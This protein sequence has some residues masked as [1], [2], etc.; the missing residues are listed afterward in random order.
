MKLLFIFLL[1][2]TSIF[3]QSNPIEVELQLKNSGDESVNS[4]SIITVVETG[5]VIRANAGSKIQI[6][7]EK[8]GFYTFKV[9]N[10]DKL[11]TFRKEVTY[12]GQVIKLYVKEILKGGIEVVG[13]KEKNKL[14]RY[15]LN[16]DEIKR[17]PGAQGDSLKAALTL[18]GV[19][20]ATPVGLLSTAQFNV[21]ITGQ[22]YRNSDRGDFVLRGAGPRANQY[23]FDGFPVSYPFHLGGQSSVFNNNLIR[24]IDVQSGVYSS[25]YGYATGGLLNIYSKNEVRRNQYTI[26]LNTF[27]SDASMEVKLGDKGFLL[28]GV[29]K[30]YPNIFLLRAFPQGIPEDAKYADY[31]DYQLKTGYEIFKGHRLTLQVFGSRDRQAYTRTQAELENSSGQPDNR[32][33]FGLDRRFNTTGIQYVFQP[34]DRFKNTLRI[35][36]NDFQ[37]LFE[38]KFTSPL[39]AE[40]VFGLQNVT[41]Q[42]LVF[43]ENISSLQI[44]KDILKLEAGLNYRYRN[45]GLKAENITSTNSLFRDVFNN[46]LNSSPT[47]RALIDGDGIKAKETGGFAELQFEYKGLRVVPGV[48]VDR[49]DLANEVQVSPRGIASYTIESWRTTFSGGGGIYRNAPVGI[50]QISRKSG[51]PNLRME[52]SEHLALGVNQEIGKDFSVKVEGFRNIFK[53][54]VTNDSFA[55][56]PYALNNNPRDLVDR[57]AFVEAN[58]I[59]PRQRFYSNSGDGFSEGFELFLKKSAPSN[60]ESGW[61]GWISYS[62]SVTKRNNHQPTLTNTERNNRALENSTRTLIGQTKIGNSYVNYYDDNRFEILYDNDKQY[63]YDLD[64][65]HIFSSVFGWRISSRWQVGGRFRYAT[66]VPITKINGST[67]V[68]QQATFGLN[69]FLPEYSDQY[70]SYRLPPVHQLD[71]RIDRFSNYDW[72]YIN[73]YIEF[74]NLYGRRNPASENFDNTRPYSPGNPSYNYDTLNSPYIRVS[75]SDGRL[76]FLP[77]I[78]FGM[79]VR[80]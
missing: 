24:E 3:S 1:S 69:L 77:M 63:L 36:R 72:G 41:T 37:E 71:I 20:P 17:L 14:S 39:T 48:R 60:G 25:R 4:S 43:I 62:N 9:L 6:S 58:P 54:L 16:Q 64:R 52:T 73:P 19:F 2:Y 65:T 51:N 46:L 74:I 13:E 27:L 5:K 78:N 29:R 66:N 79:E 40:N 38:V 57:R 34:G 44:F 26:N 33:P 35:S 50:E 32:P 12:S 23:Y 30:S 15:T 11:E 49:Y 61:F 28:S 31:G 56:D 55:Y 80:F 18:P 22:P 67:Q 53:D 8:T 21:N 7:F 10:A 47:F 42:N 59:F 68:N 76:L 45:I 70:N 75:Y